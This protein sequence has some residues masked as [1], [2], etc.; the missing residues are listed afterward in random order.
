MRLAAAGLI[1]A[2]A[3]AACVPSLHPFHFEKDVVFDA[4]LLG[5]WAPKD[6]KS[7]WAFSAHEPAAYRLVHAD[8]KGREGRFRARLF[9]LRGER[10]LDLYPEAPAGESNAYHRA[11]LVKAHTLLHVVELGPRLRLAAMNPDWLRRRLEK[12]PGL[13]AHERRGEQVVLTAP[14]AALQA[15]VLRLLGEPEAFGKPVELGRR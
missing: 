7:S 8:D 9:E 14:T 10:F 3:L 5:A 6:G 13:I 1:A 4:Q 2:L 12:D 11:H 15:F